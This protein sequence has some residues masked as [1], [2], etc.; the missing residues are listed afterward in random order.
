MDVTGTRRA[1]LHGAAASAIKA[2]VELMNA[3]N[4]SNDTNTELHI[5]LQPPVFTNI[6]IRLR[7]LQRS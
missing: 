7:T 4:E 3:I 6:N 5:S 1:H 2:T